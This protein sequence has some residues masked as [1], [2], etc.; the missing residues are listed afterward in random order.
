MTKHSTSLALVWSSI[1]ILAIVLKN[2]VAKNYLVENLGMASQICEIILSKPMNLH[3][4][5]LVL[6]LLKQLTVNIKPPS[7]NEPYLLNIIQHLIPYIT[8]VVS[9][10]RTQFSSLFV[11]AK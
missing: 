5:L 4:K 10:Y 9:N 1:S 7:L 3:K 2:S 6:K 8:I 11:F